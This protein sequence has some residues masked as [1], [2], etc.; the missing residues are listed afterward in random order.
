MKCSLP[1]KDKN[2]ILLCLK[3][4]EDYKSN[5]NPERGKS[6][7]EL[8]EMLLPFFEWYRQKEYIEIQEN[9]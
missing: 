4:K 7:N 2:P 1:L 5:A 6:I 8:N 9:G 3:I